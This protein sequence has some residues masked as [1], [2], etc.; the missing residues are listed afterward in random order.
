MLFDQKEHEADT[1]PTPRFPVMLSKQLL[2]PILFELY[3]ILLTRTRRCVPRDPS[4][5]ARFSDRQKLNWCC[6]KK[7]FFFNF[8]MTKHSRN[9]SCN[10]NATRLRRISNKCVHT[11][12]GA[13]YRNG[14]KCPSLFSFREMFVPHMHYY[15]GA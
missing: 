9:S 6:E 5:R 15:V 1:K 14:S 12:F 4:D 10:V 7:Q 8:V 3:P 11:L 2:P 13:G